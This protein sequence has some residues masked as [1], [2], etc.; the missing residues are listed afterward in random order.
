MGHVSKHLLTALAQLSAMLHPNFI[1]L[2]AIFFTAETVS[3]TFLLNGQILET[4]G[5]F[6]LKEKSS[7][8]DSNVTNFVSHYN[9]FKGY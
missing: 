2:R 5:F 6:F 4:R 7:E 1:T 3:R 8:N 9:D